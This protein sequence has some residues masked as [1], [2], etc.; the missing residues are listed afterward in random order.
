MRDGVCNSVPNIFTMPEPNG[1]T[2]PT[3]NVSNGG[4]M[5]RPAVSQGRAAPCWTGFANPAEAFEGIN[6]LQTPS[7]F[8]DFV[9]SFS[10]ALGNI[11]VFHSDFLEKIMPA[12]S[13]RLPDEVFIRLEELAKLTGR[14]KTFY[15]IK[16][17]TDHIDDLEDLYLAEQRL[18]D[19]HAGKSKTYT[20]EEVERNLGLVD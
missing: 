8:V 17:I 3:Q 2:Y 16:A 9:F 13:L 12:V 18:I 11:L 5:P 19:V 15:M 1:Y 7:R 6:N 14:S 20:L 10:R 4:N